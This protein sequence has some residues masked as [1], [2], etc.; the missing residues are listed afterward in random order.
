MG[1]PLDGIWFIG[2]ST[3]KEN[4]L[5][6]LLKLSTIYSS[7]VRGLGCETLTLQPR[8]MTGLILW[9]VLCR[10]PQV[11]RAA[12]LSRPEDT[13]SLCPPKFLA[14][15]LGPSLFLWLFWALRGGVIQMPTCGWA[16]HRHLLLVLWSVVSFCFSHQPHKSTSVMRHESYSNLW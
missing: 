7:S 11:L 14:L 15:M 9:K 16:L 10:E 13:V 8:M 5:L 12:I 6:I 3:F 2:G 1:H 4:S